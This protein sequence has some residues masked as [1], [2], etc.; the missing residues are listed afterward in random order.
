MFLCLLATPLSVILL[1][2]SETKWESV[3]SAAVYVSWV[4]PRD[5]IDINPT[6]NTANILLSTHSPWWTVAGS[7][8]ELPK[9][10]RQIFVSADSGTEH[11][12]NWEIQR[13]LEGCQCNAQKYIIVVRLQDFEIVLLLTG[14]GLALPPGLGATIILTTVCLLGREQR[15][16]QKPTCTLMYP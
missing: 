4:D 14:N 7:T 1:P 6:A 2:G 12:N 3:D 11:N 15:T 9:V 13:G 5:S 16:S 10:Q 8:A